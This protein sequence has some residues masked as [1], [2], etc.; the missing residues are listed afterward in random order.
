M[1]I[2]HCLK[3]QCP[4]EAKI[5]TTIQGIVIACFKQLMLSSI[6]VMTRYMEGQW[7]HF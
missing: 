6:L 1:Q 5:R 4:Q 7:N 3:K 2:S